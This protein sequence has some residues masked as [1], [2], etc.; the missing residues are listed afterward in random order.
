[1]STPIE[2]L[3]KSFPCEFIHIIIGLSFI[4]GFVLDYYT[5]N[6]YE[7]LVGKVLVIRNEL[8]NRLYTR[9]NVFV[10]SFALR[11]WNDYQ[12]TAV[13]ILDDKLFVNKGKSY[14]TKV[15]WY[16]INAPKQCIVFS[17]VWLGVT[18]NKASQT[19]MMIHQFATNMK[20]AIEADLAPLLW[21]LLLVSCACLCPVWHQ[22]RPYCQCKGY[23]VWTCC[24]LKPSIWLISSGKY[25]DLLLH[26]RR[27]ECTVEYDSHYRPATWA[28]FRISFIF[29]VLLRLSQMPYS[30]SYS[31]NA[32]IGCGNLVAGSS[33]L[34]ATTTE[35]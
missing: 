24:S 1:M 30:S 26:N 32:A 10:Y 31:W 11:T 5:P 6:Y 2:E 3:C 23:L 13:L 12:K 9:F 20:T 8:P 14:I 19:V 25:I 28:Y 4:F 22:I 21:S 17:K 33:I 27:C 15:W 7:S 34:I 18:Q 29:H 35:L 16:Y